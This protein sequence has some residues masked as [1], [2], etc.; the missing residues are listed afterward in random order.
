M[1]IR[2]LYDRPGAYIPNASVTWALNNAITTIPSNETIAIF[3]WMR[4]PGG[5]VF[6]NSR[7]MGG[8]LYAPGNNEL[9]IYNDGS[10][11]LR[12]RWRNAAGLQDR[13]ISYKPEVDALYVQIADRDNTRVQVFVDAVRVDDNA[14]SR[15]PDFSGACMGRIGDGVSA[16]CSHTLWRSLI[17]SIAPGST[18]T[19]AQWSAIM[20]RMLN[21]HSSI[22]PAL[23]AING[24]FAVEWRPGEGVYGSGTIQNELNP[25]T[26]DLTWQGGVTVEDVRVRARTGFRKPEKTLYG[27][28][29]GYTATTGN[30]DF[31]FAAQPVVARLVWNGH[32]TN[33][34]SGADIARIRTQASTYQLGMFDSATGIS[35]ACRESVTPWTVPVLVGDQVNGGDIWLVFS[36]TSYLV[37]LSGQPTHDYTIGEAINLSGNCLVE[38]DGS[39]GLN[40]RIAAWNPTS[41]PA[42]LEQEIRDCCMNP[43][44]DPPSLTNKRVDFPL[45]SE[46]L[47]GAASTDVP[48]QGLGG[49]TLVLSAGRDTA[50]KPMIVG[51]SP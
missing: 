32:Q 41:I 50:C 23:S 28:E 6:E 3:N 16:C 21:P 35:V 17:V 24:S 39:R 4:I 10:S 1:N 36:G 33:T 29:P 9:E 5:S 46:F 48:N 14:M 8:R 43:E 37:Y 11:R 40:C 34:G 27:L 49:G 30:V 47:T 42:T 15:D 26:D 12:F 22:H 18:P 7:Y 13:S 38:L 51:Y 20:K 25:G 44:K 31:G 2:P 45:S 19:E